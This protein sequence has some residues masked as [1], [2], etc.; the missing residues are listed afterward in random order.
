MRKQNSN[1]VRISLLTSERRRESLFQG[2]SPFKRRQRELNPA[3]R[4]LT[5]SACVRA[6][7]LVYSSSGNSLLRLTQYSARLAYGVVGV[8]FR[9]LRITRLNFLIKSVYSRALSPLLISSALATRELRIPPR[10]GPKIF[11]IL[12]EGFN[13]TQRGIV[14]RDLNQKGVNCLSE[15][16]KT[17]ISFTILSSIFYES[18][19]KL[20]AVGS[21]KL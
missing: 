7:H 13:V 8:L 20:G 15:Q 4:T 2:L 21:Y 19:R 12:W 3:A 16:I 10:A 11:W 18:T 14:P 5:Q 6:R 9:L 17:L 1:L